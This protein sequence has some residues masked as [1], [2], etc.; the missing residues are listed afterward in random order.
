MTLIM[1]GVSMHLQEVRQ[2][3]KSDEMI[4][5]CN[6]RISACGTQNGLSMSSGERSLDNI[7]RPK[8]FLRN[9]QNVTPCHQFLC[10]YKFHF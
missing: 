1:L 10:I 8:T 3:G 9:A 2:F 5:D 6:S 4:L 7:K